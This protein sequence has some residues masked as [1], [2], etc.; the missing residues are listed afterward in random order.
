MSHRKRAGEAKGKGSVERV[1]RSDLLAGELVSVLPSPPSEMGPIAQTCWRDV[2]SLIVA[3]GHLTRRDLRAFEVYCQHYELWARARAEVDKLPSLCTIS[4]TGV[5]KAHPLIQQMNVC[6]ITAD[7][8]GER[9]MITPQARS[10][11]GLGVTTST[12]TRGAFDE[13]D[14]R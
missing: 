2:G 7:R 1:I 9:F 5:E 14:E 4:S 6:A 8:L 11:A 12:P 13:F 10:R 3:A